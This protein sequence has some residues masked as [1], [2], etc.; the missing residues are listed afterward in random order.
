MAVVVVVVAV[1]GALV[2]AGAFASSGPLRRVVLG[3]APAVADP[4]FPAV[5][6]D[7]SMGFD[8]I[9]LGHGSVI[10]AAHWSAATGRWSPAVALSGAE[11][12][13]VEGLEAGLV[14][15]AP[16]GDAAGV[17]QG[18]TGAGPDYPLPSV[19]QARYRATPTGP[20]QPMITL[21]SGR[22]VSGFGFTPELGMDAKGDAFVVWGAAHGLKLAEHAAGAATWSPPTVVRNAGS[23]SFAV[24]AN[25][26]LALLWEESVQGS[27]SGPARARLYVKVKPAGRPWL[28]TVSLGQTGVYNLQGDASD[29][30]YSP[31]LTINGS[32]I[33]YATWQWPHDGTLVTRVGILGPGRK[34]RHP[35]YVTLPGSAEDPAI[36]ADDHGTATVL[37]EAP[38]RGDPSLPVKVADISS[39]GRLLDVRTLGP[40]GGN[41]DPSIVADGRG[42]VVAQWDAAAG[43][44]VV[45]QRRWCPRVNVSNDAWT[46]VAIAPDGIAQVL[47]YTAGSKQQIQAITLRACHA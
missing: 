33:V 13:G 31:R 14:A 34:W 45:G 11:H 3:T 43:Q 5:A 4:V 21:A 7:G 25:G 37:W 19:L 6:A 15:G 28:P 2:E 27:Y 1:V 44:R 18:T 10:T 16:N 38:Q 29:A 35:R 39:R 8:A 17:W 32:G 36:A 41:E 24:S 9:W 23:D 40:G 30:F 47:V 22:P 20:W 12:L 26:T 46:N 42:D